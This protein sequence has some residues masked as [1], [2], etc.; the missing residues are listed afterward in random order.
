V[1]V[2][3]LSG[4]TFG[5][6]Y[7]V[8]HPYVFVRRNEAEFSPAQIVHIRVADPYV[9]FGYLTEEAE[10]GSRHVRR[11]AAV[12]PAYRAGGCSPARGVNTATKVC[13]P[14]TVSALMICAST[15]PSAVEEA[16]MNSRIELLMAVARLHQD[17]RNGGDAPAR[18]GDD[19]H[20][21]TQSGLSSRRNAARVRCVAAVPGFTLAP[22]E[23]QLEPLNHQRVGAGGHPWCGERGPV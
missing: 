21:V 17:I 4:I 19:E 2:F 9:G 10:A 13:W 8:N 7:S 22:T 5:C 12:F 16:Q 3:A 18:Q 15:T 14:P 6:L 20:L 11:W 23:G 1:R